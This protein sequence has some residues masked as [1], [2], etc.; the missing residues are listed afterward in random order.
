MV[1]HNMIG[2]DGRRASDKHPTPIKTEMVL[3]SGYVPE[4]RRFESCRGHSPKAGRTRDAEIADFLFL[5]P[6]TGC[7]GDRILT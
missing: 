7:L 2:S 3:T 5:A 4:S 6:S 1:W